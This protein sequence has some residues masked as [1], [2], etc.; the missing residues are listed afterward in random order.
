ML[1]PAAD[2]VWSADEGLTKRAP[3]DGAAASQPRK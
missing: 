1:P 2:D 3:A